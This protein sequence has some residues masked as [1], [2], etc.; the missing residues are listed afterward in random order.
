MEQE[1]FSPV[2]N[3]LETSKGTIK[4]ASRLEARFLA[5][6]DKKAI[7]WLYEPERVGKMKYFVDFYLPKLG[8]WVEVKGILQPIDE[9]QLPQVATVLK[10]RD[11]LLFVYQSDN[12]ASLITENGFESITHQELWK[13]LELRQSWTPP[14]K[15]FLQVPETIKRR[16]NTPGYNQRKKKPY[17]E[18]RKPRQQKLF[19]GVVLNVAVLTIILT[20]II[21]ANRNNF[22]SVAFNSATAT[23]SR[24]QN[25]L[26][27]ETLVQ[28]AI[29]IS[30]KMQTQK[31]VT[32]TP[33][34]AP[35]TLPT[36]KITASSVIVRQSPGN[37]IQKVKELKTGTVVTII[38][39]AIYESEQT[40]W[41]KISSNDAIVGWI[42][43]N[44]K[45][46]EL[47]DVKFNGDI[48][49]NIDEIRP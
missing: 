13:H 39:Y 5:H 28:T 6:I 18:R 2:P 15:S 32:K 42:V 31:P 27:A 21:V 7:D 38:G 22:T 24:P 16:E 40:L 37:R 41:W 48:P 45:F 36:M 29:P 47:Y 14:Q 35:A 23:L 46:V 4:L 11:E 10:Q 19:Y 30:T 43:H 25:I 3:E 9:L 34:P 33:V 1:H 8:V 44:P 17:E 20:W 49:V 26:P 12:K